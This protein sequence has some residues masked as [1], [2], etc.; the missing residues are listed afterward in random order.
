MVIH[1]LARLTP[2]QRKEVYTAYFRENRGVSDLAR[3]Y[4]VSR[5]TIY[6]ILERGRMNDFTIH[7]STNARFRCLQYGVKRLEKFEKSIEK[8]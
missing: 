8:G 4:H 3:E 5:P 2:I 7:K 6:K 1:K